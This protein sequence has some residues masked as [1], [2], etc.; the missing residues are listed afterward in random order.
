VTAGEFVVLGASTDLADNG[1]ATVDVAWAGLDLGG[2]ADGLTLTDAYGTVVDSVSWGSGAGFPDPTGA[3]LTL[4]PGSY[5]AS[6]NDDGANWCEASSSFGDGDLGTPGAANDGCA[7]GVDAD[8]DGYFTP[9]DCDDTDPAINRGATDTPDDGIDQDCD[10][11]DAHI[12]VL[13]AVDDLVA[14]DLIVVEVLQNPDDVTDELGEWFEVYVDTLDQVDL[15][16]LVVSDDGTDVFTV[17]G[18]LIVDPG[19]YVVFTR[20]G[21]SATN[22]MVTGD[23]TW[24]TGLS[25][26]NDADELV[27]SNTAGE[28]DRIGWDGGTTWPDPSG[29]SMNLSSDSFDASVND[30]GAYWC[31]APGPWAGGDSGSPGTANILCL[32]PVTDDDGDGWAAEDDCDDTDASV[33][34]GAPETDGDGVDSNC[35]GDDDNTGPAPLPVDDARVGGI[36]VSEIMKDPDG[37]S[38]S[39][40]EWLEI[41]N[42]TGLSWELEGLEVSDAG[43]DSFTVSGSLVIGPYEWIVFGV[44][45]DLATNGG[46]TVDYVWSGFELG[47]DDDEVVL[48]NSTSVIDEVAYDGGSS[49]PD[50]TG[51]SL[52]L[53]PVLYNSSANDSGSSWCTATSSW[54]GDDLGTPGSAN[55][56]C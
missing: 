43:G 19:S 21:D 52:S 5:S 36:I 1:G 16:G 15:D 18:S 28:I 55:D 41:Y 48:S 4:D 54:A 31:E 42:T 25:L 32:V 50:P 23:Y 10:G 17:S 3:S 47:N 34:P 39:A 20:N 2:D 51:A 37:V 49:F 12:P 56:G 40:G 35:D 7:G 6:A 9:A 24:G 33:F 26:G 45:D 46:V 38:D 8:G 11:T 13:L 29:A 30:D 53:N 22:G 14:G 27:L 44:D